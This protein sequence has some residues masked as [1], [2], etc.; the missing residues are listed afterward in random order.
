MI[1]HLLDTQTTSFLNFIKYSSS[2]RKSNWRRSLIVP[3]PAIETGICIL[4]ILTWID[5]FRPM[6]PVIQNSHCNKIVVNKASLS[7]DVII[8]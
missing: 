6:K 7:H 4:G 2:C 5:E 1:Y 8:E 3:L